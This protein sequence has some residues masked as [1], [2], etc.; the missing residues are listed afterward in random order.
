MRKKLYRALALISAFMVTF[1]GL[2]L[3]NVMAAEEG[4]S[5]EVM[6]ENSDEEQSVWDDEMEQDISEEET[7]SVSKEDTEDVSEENSEEILSEE[8]SEEVTEEPS[9]EISEEVSEEVSEEESEEVSEEPEEIPE[10][11]E[12]PELDYALLSGYEAPIYHEVSAK[13]IPQDSVFVYTEEK[14]SYFKDNEWDKYASWYYYN[15]LDANGKA[16]WKI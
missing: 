5:Q 7:E 4:M 9:E 11:M 15:K 13:D 14:D 2:P 16:F 3:S 10:D 6:E 1:S 12:L 8:A